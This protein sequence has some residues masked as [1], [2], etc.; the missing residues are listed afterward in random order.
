MKKYLFLI[1]FISITTSVFSQEYIGQKSYLGGTI[2]ALSY[3]GMYS[4][5][6]SIVSHT[7]MS[8]SFFYAHNI[9]LPRQLFIRGELMAGEMAGDNREGV[10]QTTDPLKGGFRGYIVEGS[11]KAEYDI[12]DLYNTKITPYINAGFGAYYLFDYESHQGEEK[13]ADESWGFVAPVGGGF[14]YRLSKRV[15]VFAEGTYR[16]FP[17]NLDNFPDKT[18]NNP[19][20]YYSVVLGASIS[21]QRFNRLW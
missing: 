20:R 7:S 18:A 15:R 3:T 11:A 1:L 5:N 13:T 2:G 19:N 9:V 12:F 10:T 6:A 16:L 17:R 14:K 21:L 8:F 4:K